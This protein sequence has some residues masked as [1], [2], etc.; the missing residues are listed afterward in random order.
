MSSRPRG[1][2]SENPTSNHTDF[3]VCIFCLKCPEKREFENHIRSHIGEK[4]FSCRYCGNSYTATRSL[5]KHLRKTSMHKK[6]LSG[7][8]PSMELKCEHCQ[9]CFRN[10][11]LLKRH[12]RSHTG[13]KPFS[14]NICSKSFSQNSHVQLH[15]RTHTGEKRFQ[16]TCCKKGFGRKAELKRHLLIHAEEKPFCCALCPKGF[17]NPQNLQRHILIHTGELPYECHLCSYNFNQSSNLK[18]HMKNVH[19]V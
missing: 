18:R 15:G 19:K 12:I 10:S 13:E 16:C 3:S 6:L 8:K 5:R 7:A 14:C 2:N 4:P 9:M 17:R 11:F 1:V